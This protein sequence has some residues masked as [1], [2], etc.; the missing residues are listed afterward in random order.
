MPPKS[1]PNFTPDQLALL[2]SRLNIDP[3]SLSL[4]SPA[5]GRNAG[6]L[7]DV[8]ESLQAELELTRARSKAEALLG[9]GPIP[10][11][12]ARF[13]IMALEIQTAQSEA[14]TK[15]KGNDG[16]VRRRTTK[17]FSSARIED[18]KR[19]EF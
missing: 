18:L 3:S 15:A 2:A 17:V 9:P 7:D 12:P 19:S 13:L 16:M 5:L 10:L 1:L 4:P 11:V 6:S 14:Q 8:D